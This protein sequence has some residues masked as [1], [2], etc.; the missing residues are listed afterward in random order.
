MSNHVITAFTIGF[1]TAFFFLYGRYA[2][3]LLP[4]RTRLQMVIGIL[5]LI[6]AV[7]TAKGIITGFPEYRHLY[8]MYELVIIDGWKNITYLIFLFELIHPNWTTWRRFFM[9]ALPFI[10]ASAIYFIWPSTSSLVVYIAFIVSYNIAISVYIWIKGVSLT[11]YIHQ[12]YSNI[13]NIDISWLKY[14]II[15][16][17]LDIITWIIAIIFL[18]PL[19]EI[20]YYV[21]L[22]ILWQIIWIN[23]LNQKPIKI[24]DL[25]I[26]SPSPLKEYSFA[27]KIEQQVEKEQLYLNKDLTL[28][29]MAQAV[30]TNR[31]YLSDYFCNVKKTTFYDYINRLRI[32]QM[33]TPLIQQHPEY[34]FE[35]I[36]N[37][38]GF[39]SISTFR[40]AF[41]KFTGK[42]PSQ[43][44]SD[45][46][47]E[48]TI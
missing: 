48:D 18:I 16:G 19:T 17:I 12:N 24:E 45:L 46:T 20:I 11:R 15:L 13:E 7:W 36:A 43:Y 35:Y 10:P 34:T 39:K 8:Y 1:T 9:L 33:A 29:D 31:T 32:E 21:M 30:K 2:L 3:V 14:V 38:S 41:A 5:F 37:K 47:F 27:G 23:S 26:I 25:S 40:R 28:A 42:S 4:N 22:V 6:R 44:R